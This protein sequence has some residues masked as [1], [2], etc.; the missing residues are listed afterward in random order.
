MKN[1]IIR[2]I[3]GA[4]YVALVIGAILLGKEAFAG[5]TLLFIMLSVI[6]ASRLFQ[7]GKPLDLLTMAIDVAGGISVFIGLAAPYLFNPQEIDSLPGYAAVIPFTLYLLVRLTVELFMSRENPLAHIWSS[8]L[9]VIYA[10]FPLTL[11]FLL[12][13][14][15]GYKVV[16]AMFIFI[17]LNDT[18]AFCVGSLIGKHKLFE[19]VSPKKSWEGVWGGLAFCIIAGALFGTVG[20]GYFGDDY[21]RWI[22]LGITTSVLATIGD[23]VESLFKR[24][25]G[26]KDSGNIMPGHGGILDRLDSLLFVAPATLCL[27]FFY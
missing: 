22:V 21:I 17:W 26:V 8:I 19:R 2:S 15:A 13:A 14:T 27:L 1:V 10:A 11:M 7:G 18:G 4:V 9:A 5:L 24:T 16:L 6:E 3:S 23:L 25:V 12:Y 20:S